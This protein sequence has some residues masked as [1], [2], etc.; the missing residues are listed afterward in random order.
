MLRYIFW[1]RQ[2][3]QWL[4]CYC[5]FV[6]PQHCRFPTNKVILLLLS[7]FSDT[8]CTYIFWKGAACFSTPCIQIAYPTCSG[9][10][11]INATV[12]SRNL[13]L[14]PL[15]ILHACNV[16]GAAFIWVDVTVGNFCEAEFCKAILAYCFL[17]LEQVLFSEIQKCWTLI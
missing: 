7:I 1:N 17:L 16:S 3:S 13:V 12:E 9:Q 10:V 2:I 5:P 8:R 14:F 15:I 4:R 11:G 6:T